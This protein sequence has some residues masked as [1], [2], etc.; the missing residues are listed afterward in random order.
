MSEEDDETLSA[1]LDTSYEAYKKK[2][3][4]KHLAERGQLTL[5]Q[6]AALVSHESH[7]PTISTIKLEDLFDFHLEANSS[8]E[9]ASEERPAKTTASKKGLAK[10]PPKTAPAKGPAKKGP[11]PKTA[12]VAK[13]GPAKR[14]PAPKTAKKVG[15][16]KADKGKPKP[17]LDYELGTK[18]LLAALKAA[19]A[20]VGRGDLEKATSYTAVQVRAFCKK[21]AADGKIVVTGK[22]GRSTRYAIK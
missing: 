14:G 12:K 1:A 8:S 11:A 10:A 21:L 13:K 19:N 4:I 9:E 3:M 15:S 7:G 17:R 2:T 18:E 6:I 20:P 5:A 22:G 16:P